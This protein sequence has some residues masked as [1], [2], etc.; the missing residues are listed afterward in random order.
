[1]F[2]GLEDLRGEALEREL[3][4]SASH[5][6]AAFARQLV[7]IRV[8]DESGE[9]ANYG[10]RSC[11]HFLDWRLGMSPVIA[12][13]RV[14]IARALG[15]LP[16]TLEALASGELSYSKVRAITRVARPDNEETLLDF[17]RKTTAAQLETICRCYRQEQRDGERKPPERNVTWRPLGDG[18]VRIGATLA[19][20]EAEIV[21]ES[22]QDAARK[23]GQEAADASAAADAEAADAPEKTQRFCE[24]DVSAESPSP[25]A[26]PG[27][28]PAPDP[29]AELPDPYLEP[30]KALEHERE[31]RE[32]KPD[33]FERSGK[34]RLPDALVWL[35][36]KSL[37][38]RLDTSKGAEMYQI[39]VHLERDALEP[40]GFKAELADGTPLS[41]DVFRRI[42]CDA[43]LVPARVDERGNVL[44]IGRKR[45]TI[46]P[47]IRRA[48]DMRDRKC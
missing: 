21:W 11:A 37:A 20:D 14:R 19:A 28:E 3:V 33:A 29:D 39:L 15:Q 43:S 48:L 26:E 6:D 5:V 10:A 44:D 12:R 4:G 22:L 23:A 1:M 16:R 35:C 27:A 34:A 13:E 30:R 7:L 2:E 42:A 36:E 41:S 24:N 32:E 38:G 8:C 31:L 17:A 46:P 40:G 9:W 25:G 45:R 47:A 18:M